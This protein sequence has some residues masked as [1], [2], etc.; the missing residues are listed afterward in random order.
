[1]QASAWRHLHQHSPLI[2]LSAP[3]PRALLVTLLLNLFHGCPWHDTEQEG[4]LQFNLYLF[5]YQTAETWDVMK[6]FDIDVFIFLLYV[7]E[8]RYPQI[9]ESYCLWLSSKYRNKAVYLLQACKG[10]MRPWSEKVLLDHHKS[11]GSMEPIHRLSIGNFG[12]ENISLE[13]VV[14]ISTH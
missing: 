9:T 11:K 1:M 5:I 14:G 4:L 13:T 8:L 7:T 10:Y 6:V 12:K 3:L 2:Q